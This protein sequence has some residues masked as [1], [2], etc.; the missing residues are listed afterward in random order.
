MQPIASLTVDL[1]TLPHYHAIHGLPALWEEVGALDPAY[2]VAMPRMLA[3]FEEVRA[4]ATLFVIGQD[5][6]AHQDLL[7]QAHQAGHELG[8]HTF[9]HHY[10]LRS[11]RSIYIE[12]EIKRAEEAIAA[13]TGAAP[14]GFRTPGYNLSASILDILQKRGYCYDSSIFP[15]PP[16]YVAKGAIMAARALSGQPSRSAMTQPTTLLAPITPYR[17]SATALWRH[18]PHSARPLEIPM[19]VVPGA[20]F[21]LIGTSLHLIGARGFDA[22]YP[23]LRRA[24]PDL[25]QL[26]LHALDFLD[27]HDPGCAALASAQPDLR[28]PWPKKRARYVHIFKALGAHYT[29]AT[30]ADAARAWERS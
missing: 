19:C 29:L 28:V 13:V 25:F 18:D 4:K 1:D 24:H 27:A 6:A 16:Y 15:C 30:L 7:S 12:E 20:R 23:L 26:E 11:R 9:S 17:P 2:T 3:L 8:N 10:D 14:V 22:L 21:P 5:V